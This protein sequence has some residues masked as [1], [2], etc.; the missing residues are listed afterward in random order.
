MAK[1]NISGMKMAEIEA[2]VC[3]IPLANT[4]NR[5][6]R[7]IETLKLAGMKFKPV[8]SFFYSEKPV[9]EYKKYY[10]ARNDMWVF[11]DAQAPK[12]GKV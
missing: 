11:E 1:Y 5:F 7:L 12:E 6:M 9:L 2:N 8:D 3:H 10:D 4:I